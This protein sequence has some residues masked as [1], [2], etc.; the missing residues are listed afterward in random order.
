MSSPAPS[1][2]PPRFGWPIAGIALVAGCFLATGAAGLVYEILWNKMLA[3]LMGNTAYALATLLTVFMGGLALGAWLG[4]R[5]APSGSAGL[6][7]YGLLEVLVGAYCLALPT[8]LDWTQPLFGAI[9]RNFYGSL[10]TFNFLQFLVVSLLLLLPTACM[11]ATLPILVRFL[12][13]GL[14]VMGRTVG[15]LY[16]INS[17]GAFVGAM[18]AGL[19]LLPTWGMAASYRLAVATNVGVGSIAIALWWVVRRRQP[20]ETDDLGDGE[21]RTN[22]PAERVPSRRA[23]LWGFGVCGFAAMVY[24][25]AWTRAVALA[26]G[27]S[28]YAFTLIAGAFILGLTA[29]SLALGWTADRRAGRVALGLL[30]G[31]IGLSSI[32]TVAELGALP[33]EVTRLIRTAETFAQLEWAKFRAVFTVFLLPTFCMGGL[34]PLVSRFLATRS[35]EAGSSVGVAYAANAAGTILGSFCAGFVLIPWIGIRASILAASALSVAVGI[36]WLATSLRPAARGI[37]ALPLGAAACLGL[38]WAPAWTPYVMSSG[39]F[40]HAHVHDTDSSDADADIRQAMERDVLFYEEGVTGV[41]AV[42]GVDTRYLVVG[43]LVDATSKAWSQAWLGHLPAVLHRDAKKA[44]VIGL[45]SGQTLEAVAHHRRLDSIQC[46]EISEEVVRAARGF[47]LPTEGSPLDDPRVDLVIGD[48]RLHLQHT[49]AMFDLIVSQ[50]S[51]FWLAGSAALFTRENFE[52][53]RARLAPGGLACTWFQSINM[54]PETFR[55]LCRTWTDVWPHASLWRSQ[56]LGEYVF[57]G[58]E[59]PLRPAFDQLEA[60]YADPELAPI[61][62]KLWAPTSAHL[63]GFMVTADA[64]L[65]ALGGSGELNT[66][67]LPHV[68]HDMPR[69][70]FRDHSRRI[71]G[72]LQRHRVDPW[73]YV[74]GDPESEAFLLTRDLSRHITEARDASVRAMD[75][76]PG[77]RREVWRQVLAKDPRDIVAAQLMMAEGGVGR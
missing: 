67:D 21:V 73:E 33:I 63:M 35:E 68:A 16:G 57:V 36:G 8:L 51:F 65:R 3:L 20:Q 6:L 34:L 48:G 52:L 22:L 1:A 62:G 77:E 50:P 72:L 42:T 19:V 9:Y 12:C 56:S 23:L 60:A 47:F 25:V 43:G 37:L 76:P 59:E 28:T 40:Y 7:V 38:W 46:V 55:T 32:W 70:M 13:R 75:L 71:L 18:L 58:S 64:S 31:V 5:W 2:A 69:G 15:V 54:E 74:T 14:G 39:A 53:M 24:Q 45:G 11:G 10:A 61:L 49:D 30:P 66:D 4:G 44:L 27:S 41:V 29:G 26:I 17:G